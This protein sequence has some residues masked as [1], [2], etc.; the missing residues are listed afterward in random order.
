MQKNG[1]SVIL[2][3]QGTLWRKARM[4][5]PGGSDEEHG[6][7]APGAE[8]KAKTEHAARAIPD[9]LEDLLELQK[10]GMKVL[11]P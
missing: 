6:K 7:T 1:L 2:P 8:R 5:R 4:H 10:C 11:L 9:G 3:S